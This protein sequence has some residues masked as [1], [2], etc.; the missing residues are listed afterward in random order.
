M[1]V[2]AS[3]SS[4]KHH[5]QVTWF[6]LTL[7]LLLQ[8]PFAIAIIY[9][10]PID[11]QSGAT[12]YEVGTY[13]LTAFLIWWERS[14]LADFHMDTSALFLIIFFRPLQT[15]ILSHWGVDT[16]LAFPRPF[17]LV[18]WAISIGLFFALWFS[19]YKPARLTS[20]TLGWLGL[21]LFVGVFVSVLDNLG[22]F[23]SVFN[24][25]N[26]RPIHLLPLFTS[27]GLNL[28]Y[29]LGFSPI[30]EEPLFRGFLWGCLRQIKWKEGWIWLLQAGLFTL[31]H[32]YF[33]SQYPFMFWVFIPGAGLLFGFLTM[34]SRSIS[35]GILAHGMINGS[36]YLLLL[37]LISL[38][39]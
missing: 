34:R 18:L 12:L 17:G 35:P 2:E 28:V 3:A 20:L 21:G 31:A 25:I 26:T 37:N 29:H 11:N 8:I 36:A 15:L 22:S 33:A 6:V 4:L 38:L 27:T 19:G 16:P 14:R 32:I 39:R 7:L 24:N 23:R 10:L 5:G 9:L 30:N 13:L 1:T